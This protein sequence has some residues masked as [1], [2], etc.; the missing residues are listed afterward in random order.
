[1]SDSA[2][3][4]IIDY[5]CGNPASIRN[6]LKKAGVASVITRD[7]EA[8]R[9]ADRIVFPGVGSFDF[10]AQS[11]VSLGIAEAL[12]ER[13][14]GA[15]VPLLAICVGMQLLA[16]RSDEG[17]QPGLGWIDGEVV[18]F[19]RARLS[20]ADKVP[21]MGWA[22]ITL[23][24]PH[25]V[26]EGFQEAPRFYFVHSFHMRCDR[27]ENVAATAHHGYDF[28]A[29]V[30]HGNILGVQFHPEKSHRFGMH[31]LSNFAKHAFSTQ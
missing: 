18:G 11:I 28:C 9:K 19:D 30:A 27:Q 10:G 15:G 26:F 17:V 31:L 7:A 4:T 6:M 23:P 16:R 12:T 13:V 24:R 8:I 1:M 14:I 25:P 20:H 22:D 2:L 3:I 21:H 29:A 5:G